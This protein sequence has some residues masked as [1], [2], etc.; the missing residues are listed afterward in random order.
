MKG[1]ANNENLYKMIN[2]RI[3]KSSGEETDEEGCLSVPEKRGQVVRP[4]N[5]T[6]E[7]MDINGDIVTLEGEGL[8]AR[9]I[10]H[11]LDHLDGILFIDKI[12][13]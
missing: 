1:E 4:S 3:I 13:N 11:E 12:Q 5:V 10:C 8:L 2:P 9:C 7:Y 6:V